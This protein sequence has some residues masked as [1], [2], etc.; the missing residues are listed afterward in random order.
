[1]FTFI[2]THCLKKAAGKAHSI[3]YQEVLKLGHRLR[4]RDKLVM[5]FL[6]ILLSQKFLIY[7]NWNILRICI[8]FT[9]RF[10]G[11]HLGKRDNQLAV[12]CLPATHTTRQE[13]LV[14][15]ISLA[16]GSCTQCGP[17]LPGY[18]TWKT[19]MRNRKKKWELLFSTLMLVTL[20]FWFIFKKWNGNGITLCKVSSANRK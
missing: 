17:L 12:W 11:K 20:C 14:G 10:F 13:P 2:Y 8:C 1:M 18:I 3:K 16:T 4:M 19:R 5:I 6:W 7:H 9:A 15:A